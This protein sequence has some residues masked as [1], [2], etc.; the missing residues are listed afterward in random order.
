MYAIDFMPPGTLQANV[1]I[2]LNDDV[3]SGDVSDVMIK[4]S[5]YNTLYCK[6]GGFKHRYLNL[7]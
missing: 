5:N 7:V 4:G 6:K 1:I 2:V 3:V